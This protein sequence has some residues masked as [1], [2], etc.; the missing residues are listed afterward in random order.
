MKEARL[1]LLN[2]NSLRHC[3]PRS[4]F[5]GNTEKEGEVIETEVKQEWRDGRSLDGDADLFVL[6][7]LSDSSNHRSL[8]K[9]CRLINTTGCLTLTSHWPEIRV[10]RSNCD[11]YYH[12]LLWTAAGLLAVAMMLTPC[13]QHKEETGVVKS[14]VSILKLEIEIWSV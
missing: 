5:T 7:A 10:S 14:S 1:P 9:T 12:L 3:F 2:Q 4:L 8:Y 6:S 11:S 13:L